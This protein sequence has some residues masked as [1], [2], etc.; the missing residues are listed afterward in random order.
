MLAMVLATPACG[1]RPP[2]AG[3]PRLQRGTASAIPL[4]RY[5]G[6]LR[7]VRVRAAGREWRLLLDTGGG[8][9]LVSPA[10]ADALGCIARGRV[11]G[12]RMTGEPFVSQSCVAPP[13]EIAGWRAPAQTLG[14]FDL[15]ALLPAGWPRVDGLLSL[16][17]FAG[18]RVTLDLA[19]D[20]L[21]VARA[22]AD[23][24]PP[25]TRV[26]GRTASGPS[27][28]E[29]LVYVGVPVTPDTLW[30][31]VDSGNLGPVLLAPHAA[32]L[33]GVADSV[34][35]EATVQLPM[36][37][38]LTE[39]VAILVRELIL[40]GALNAAWLERGRLTFDLATGETWWV[41]RR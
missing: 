4:E 9:T 11:V 2:A 33:L 6:R 18:E 3:G 23:S 1:T 7:L 13:L 24:A 19:H 39:S 10:M 29:L 30:L 8:V 34:G 21:L 40:D 32:R 28:A 37:P 15:M 36:A 22:R 25:G 27:G 26:P 38:G 14:V 12:H 41:P 35:A 20:T 5:Q 17:T 31:L 16:R